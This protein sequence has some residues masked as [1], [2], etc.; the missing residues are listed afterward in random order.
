MKILSINTGLPK[1]VEW[2]GKKVRS[3]IFKTRVEGPQK[4][5]FLN[6]GTDTQ[7]ELKFHGGRNKALYS[8]DLHYYSQWKKKIEFGDWRYGIFGENLTTEGLSDDVVRVGN[9]YRAGTVSFRAIQPRIPCFKLNLPFGRKDILSK[10][11]ESGCYGTYF[12]VEEEGLLQAGDTIELIDQSPYE[13]TIAD[14]AK[15]YATKGR[16]Q[17]LLKKILDLPVFPEGIRKNYEKFLL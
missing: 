4:V 15:S 5:T 12:R 14:F 10:F 7:C 1:T 3:S 17:E 2:D 8:F 13:I 11:Y 9:L 16:N 6:V